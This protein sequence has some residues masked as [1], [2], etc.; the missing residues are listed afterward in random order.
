M[1]RLGEIAFAICLNLIVSESAAERLFSGE[2][3]LRHIA[4]QI[5]FTYLLLQE[6]IFT[7]FQPFFI[8]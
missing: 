7:I 8:L 4:N 2:K 3:A 5:A 6:N 1:K